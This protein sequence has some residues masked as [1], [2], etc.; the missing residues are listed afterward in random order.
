MKTMELPRMKLKQ[1][2]QFSLSSILPKEI[3]PLTLVVVGIGIALLI[4]S[5]GPILF[6]ASTAYWYLSRASAM[7]AFVLLWTSMALGVSITNKLSRIW[8]GAP[9]SFELHQYT[10]LLGW[11]F[12]IFHVLILLGDNYIGYNPVQL[13]LPFA[14]TGY[15]QIW[16]GV[17][18]IAFYLLIPI[19][20]SFYL[21]K[22]IGTRGWR[23]LHGLS[24]AF[25][26]LSLVHGLFSGTDSGSVWTTVLYWFTALSLA[27]LTAYRVLVSRQRSQ[28]KT[29]VSSVSTHGSRVTQMNTERPAA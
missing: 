6:G 9:T 4:A 18:Q 10:S 12:A 24:Y 20:L 15:E 3:M 17:G 23:T 1:N 19:T 28:K 27:G 29:A 2:S 22:R 14:S 21:R 13:L 16:V 5:I 26:G 8:P 25:F 7:V 11:A